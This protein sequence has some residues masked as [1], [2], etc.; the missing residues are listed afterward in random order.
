MGIFRSI[1]WAGGFSGP[2]PLSE[3]YYSG[4][5]SQNG[6]FLGTTPKTGGILWTYQQEGW[7]DFSVDWGIF[8]TSQQGGGFLG[9]SFL[10]MVSLGPVLGT[11]QGLEDLL[12]SNPGL[13]ILLVVHNCKE[14]LLGPY[15]RLLGFLGPGK[16][17]R[18]RFQLS[19]LSPVVGQGS[20]KGKEFLVFSTS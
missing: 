5:S 19:P 11:R 12:K 8:G 15:L 20:G 17:L 18:E 2:S 16:G 7:G 9:T 14:R 4:T 10:L 1:P 3:K 13:W 6:G